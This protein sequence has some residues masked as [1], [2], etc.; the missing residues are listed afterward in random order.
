MHIVFSVVLFVPPGQLL[1]SSQI[2]MRINNSVRLRL[3]VYVFY[4]IRQNSFFRA[5]AKRVS[6][7]NLDKFLSLDGRCL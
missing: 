1:N 6:I 3:T 5:P 4:D 2:M 7:S